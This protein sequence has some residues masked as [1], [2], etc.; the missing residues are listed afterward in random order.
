[1]R[2]KD[3][4]KNKKKRAQKYEKKLSIGGSLDNVLKVSVPK[5]KEK[6]E[7]FYRMSY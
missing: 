7:K 4:N 3:V 6:E 1:M 5:T 2:E